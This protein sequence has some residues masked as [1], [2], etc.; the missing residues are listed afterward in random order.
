MTRNP[1]SSPSI[2]NV[3]VAHLEHTTVPGGAEFA[4]VRMFEAGAPW[5]P[6]LL[7]PPT[8]DLGVF[9]SAHGVQVRE[10]GVIQPAGASSRRGWFI[11]GATV[12]LLAQAIATRVHP[13]FRRADVVDANTARA[14]AYGALAAWTSRVPFVVHL[15]DMVDAEALGGFG[16]RLMSRVVL[17]RVDGVIADTEETLASAR[18]FLRAEA[19]TAVI[20]SASGIAPL[21]NRADR[22]PGEP[23]RIGMLA[24]LDP[25]KGQELLLESFAAAFPDG[26]ERLELAGGAPFDHD[27]FIGVLRAKASELGVADR[28]GLL[29]HVEDVDSVLSRWD[30][31]VQASLRPEPLGQNVLQGLA[32][33][34]AV[35][36]ADE[37]GPTEWVTHDVNGL[38]FAPRDASSLTAALRRLAD[39]GE[40]RRRLSA[41]AAATPGL[42]SD[43]EVADA[44]AEFYA[45]VLARH[46]V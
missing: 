36:V 6:L 37:G 14:A 33:G 35:V 10:T 34:C 43:A 46:R 5:R 15:R 22:L 3:R 17:P 21:S 39:D 19:V 44:H 38:R 41:A 29:G 8:A 16:F 13:G 7:L 1:R 12:R 18:P 9:G 26:T 2:R 25:W 4:L 23:L 11:F 24:R 28:V 42:L 20:M 32:A 30:I 45:D 31:A 40:L 27:D